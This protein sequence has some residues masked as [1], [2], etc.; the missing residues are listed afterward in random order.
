MAV[1][2][3]G[4]V[5]TRGL[6]NV[7]SIAV[8]EV[9][10]YLHAALFLLCIAYTAQKDGHVR[11]D[12]LYRDMSPNA[13]AWVNACGAVLLLLP[14]AIFITLT[15]WR[16]VTDSW[17]MM[18][19]SSNPGGLPLVFLLKTLIPVAGI[20][21]GIRAVSEVLRQLYQISFIQEHE[22]LEQNDPGSA[23]KT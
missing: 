19:G 14:F 15:S 1:I 3:F 4:I 20:L 5:V 13:K 11:V 10:T 23:P 12:V 6:F 18:E 21:M 22:T 17:G 7:G 16:F 9:V 2:T 8:Q